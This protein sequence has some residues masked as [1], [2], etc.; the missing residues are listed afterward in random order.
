VAHA[1]GRAGLDRISWSRKL[2]GKHAPA[3]RYKLIVTASL[4]GHESS[5]SI[6]IR[7]KT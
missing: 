3:G 4:N 2:H 7:L 1:E 6:S 5:S